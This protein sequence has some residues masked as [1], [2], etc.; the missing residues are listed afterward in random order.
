MRI[1]TQW[2][3]WLVPAVYAGA[4]CGSIFVRHFWRLL[5][6]AAGGALALAAFDML[7]QLHL[8]PHDPAATAHSVAAVV[9]L[10]I[11]FLGWVIARYSRT[12]L[13]REPGERRYVR[14]LLLTLAAVTI[15][16]TTGNLAILILAWAA[17]SLTLHQLLTFYPERPAARIAARKKFIT[18]RLAELCLLAA[19]TLLYLH[20]GTLQ[21][22]R[23]AQLAAASGHGSADVDLA[24]ALLAAAVLLKSAQFPL[25]G[26]LTQV[27]EAPTSVSA[28]LHAGI[29]NLGGYVL[30]R[31]A[32]LISASVAAQVLLVVVGGTTAV[33]AGLTMLTCPSVKVRLA[34]STCSQ[35]GLMIVECG[36]GLYAL[37]L[38]HLLAHAL[39][40]AHAFL[41]SGEAVRSNTVQRLLPAAGSRA[42]GRY[43]PLLAAP[44]AMLLVAG[45]VLLWRTV[46]HGF[47]LQWTAGLICSLGA[48]TL[49]RTG[50]YGP[51]SYLPKGLIA[52]AGVQM[53]LI[54]HA[55]IARELGV[56]SIPAAPLLGA[57]AGVCVVALYLLQWRA[58]LPTRPAWVERVFAWAAA[59]YWIDQPLTG[60]M[61][62]YW[63]G[64]TASRN[65]ARAGGRVAQHE[66]GAA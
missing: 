37:A 49:L 60:F 58:I 11:T 41:A 42:I 31:L 62:A 56:A 1:D 9:I 28:L 5:T 2:M 17:S 63:P 7:R 45:S 32:P 65:T 4:A 35:M 23:L 39:Y 26:W 64:R 40:K 13:A 15:V 59:G 47:E 25:H 50:G 29:I 46:L 57:W 14:N 36:L 43:A 55:L 3:I 30:I 34:W 20:T 52:V 44:L 38:L 22:T 27:M 24:A 48:A 54:W 51:R 53:Y 66:G 6:A 21:L 18:S 19:A 12:N 33:L 10:L 61:L 8:D 16:V